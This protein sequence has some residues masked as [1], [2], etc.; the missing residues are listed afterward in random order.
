MPSESEDPGTSVAKLPV[1]ELSTGGSL[2]VYKQIC[3]QRVT[4]ISRVARLDLLP[5]SSQAHSQG[6]HL[7]CTRSIKALASDC[8]AS[9]AIY[10]YPVPTRLVHGPA[11]PAPGCAGGPQA[12]SLLRSNV[13]ALGRPPIAAGRPRA[14]DVDAPPAPRKRAP[15]HHQ[16]ALACLDDLQQGM[17]QSRPITARG[18]LDVDR[19]GAFAPPRA[20]LSNNTHTRPG[21]RGFSRSDAALPRQAITSR[22]GNPCDSAWLAGSRTPL[23]PRH[24]TRDM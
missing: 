12:S 20:V 3:R 16:H 19:G 11:R 6:D 4:R 14:P 10:G 7:T 17:I 18:H 22:G 13:D 2:V 21:G 5:S 9:L 23:Q 15:R 24:F 1:Y 8:F